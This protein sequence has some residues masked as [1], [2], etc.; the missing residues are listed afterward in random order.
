MAQ[1]I[2]AISDRLSSLGVQP[3]A[4]ST[5]EVIDLL[6][7]QW[8]PLRPVHIQDHFDPDDIR[9]SLLYTDVLLSDRGFQLGGMH[10]R[11]ISLKILP[12]QTYASIAQ[13]LR[14]LPFNSRLQLSVHVPEQG[15]EI[16][17]LK[18]QRRLTYS[19]AYGSRGMR[20]VEG[21]AK[22]HDIETLLEN[23]TNQ[24]ER[25]FLMNLMITLR[26]ENE[27]E[28]DSQVSETLATLRDLGG[29]EGMEESL[30]AFD[31]FT[32]ASLPNARATDRIRRMKTS[33]L[34][35]L[36][37]IFGPWKGHESP[38]IL[39]QSTSGNLVPFDPFAS[40]LT[41]AN[42]IIC[43]TAGSGK[44][45]LTNALLLQLLREN[46]RVF[47]VDIGGSYKK[48]CENLGGQYLSLSLDSDFAFNPFD[49]PGGETSPDSQKTKFLLGLVDLMTREDGEARLPKLERAEIEEAIQAVFQDKNPSLS[50][51]R[52]RL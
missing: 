30:I 1:L 6:Y 3:K 22:Y 26:S 19:I 23:L 2:E 15:K 8:N 38:S 45:F 35:D 31:L 27:E 42:Q 36:M 24:G 12:E 5:Q 9:P 47:I 13:V 40:E 33:N 4:L 32:K 21:E 51:L 52:D 18:T 29:A 28:L 41:S 37:P 49:L 14:N 43:G 7:L 46:P 16:E 44:S 17:R 11:V 39:L 20:D 48:L 10:Y 34:A 25:I 50:A